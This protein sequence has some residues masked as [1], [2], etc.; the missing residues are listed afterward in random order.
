[1]RENPS[2]FVRLEFNEIAQSKFPS[3]LLQLS[4]G[5]KIIRSPSTAAATAERRLPSP[6]SGASE[7]EF[8]TKSVAFALATLA[9]PKIKVA[10]KIQRSLF[11]TFEPLPTNI[12]KVIHF[13]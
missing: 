13:A 7:F 2:L 12:L 4:P 6:A 5:L 9:R 8:T 11:L 3:D 10:A 1:V